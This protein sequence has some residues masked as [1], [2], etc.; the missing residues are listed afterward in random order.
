M[1]ADRSAAARIDPERR[2]AW[3]ERDAALVPKP[4]LPGPPS[5]TPLA[6]LRGEMISP[7]QRLAGKLE[8]L[9]DD[10][11]WARSIY[12][13]FHFVAPGVF[14]SAQPSARRLAQAA[15]LGI[16]TVVNLRGERDCATFMEETAACRRLGLDL[17]NFPMRA[18]IPPRPERLLA[19]C[20][21]FDAAP[22][23]LLLHCKTG[24]DRTGFASALYLL[25]QRGESVAR[26]RAQLSI[27]YGHF[28]S[29]RAGVLGVILASYEAA[30][31]AT[32]IPLRSWLADGYDPH[33]AL[34]DFRPSR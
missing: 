10:D 19:L 24:A 15:A 30:R 13:N 29:T 23:P 7:G 32:G 20:E 11:G 25:D 26:A 1:S 4:T 34:R 18:R 9:L 21:L 17:V 3:A 14:R 27:R 31:T 28:R 6:R 16:R 5:R 33:A 2:R 12:W 8:A 22:G